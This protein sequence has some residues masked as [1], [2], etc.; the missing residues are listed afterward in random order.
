MSNT[1]HKISKPLFHIFD[2]ES[3]KAPLSKSFDYLDRIKTFSI[4]QPKKLDNRSFGRCVCLVFF[5]GEP[6]ISIGP[7]CNENLSIFLVF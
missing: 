5:K 3:E 6:L 7:H 4:F 2:I 1:V